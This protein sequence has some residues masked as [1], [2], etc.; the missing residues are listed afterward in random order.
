M[1]KIKFGSVL[2]LS[3]LTISSLVLI[4]IPKNIEVEVKAL[5]REVNLP[6]TI[7]LNNATDEEIREYYSPLLSLSDDELKGENLLKNLKPI[8]SNNFTY[9]SYDNVWKAYEITDRNWD[10]APAEDMISGT[11][12]ASDNTITGYK[13]DY[14][15]NSTVVESSDAILKILY[16]NDNDTATDLVVTD[17]GRGSVINREH[18]WPQSRGF[19]A[20]SG[21]EGP[22]GTDL[23]HLLPGDANVNQQGHNN[24]AYGYV[25]ESNWTPS[26]TN[27]SDNDRGTPMHESTLNQ[28]T[29][30]FEPQDIDK[31]DIARACFYMVAR[32][33]N[34]AGETGVISD[35]EP[36]LE[37]VDYVTPTSGE[38]TEY[39]SDTHAVGYGV[40]STLL[41][42]HKLDPVDEFEIHR[43]NLIYNNYQNN[44]NPFIDFPCWV[45][46]IW[47]DAGSADVSND[48]INSYPPE[49]TLTIEG[50]YESTI[51]FGS[52]FDTSNIDVFVTDLNGENIEEV[53][54]FASFSNVDTHKLGEQTVTVS[55]EGL[56]TSFVINVTNVGSSE[57]INNNEVAYL[58]DLI[59]ST[60][61]EGS[62]NNKAIEI[63]NGTGNDIDL[64]SYSLR[65]YFNGKVEPSSTFEL[66]GILPHNSTYSIAHS[67]S[68]DALKSLVDTTNNVVN[69][70]GNDTIMLYKGEEKIDQFGFDPTG[71]TPSDYTGIDA[72]GAQASAKDMTL[73][74]IK[75]L[76]V[77]GKSDTFTFT[78]WVSYP[79]DTFDVLDTYRVD[80]ILL[81][82]SDMQA[83]AYAS[84]FLTMTQENCNQLIIQDEDV[85]N[86]L[87]VE[88]EAM[89]E[90][91]K[92]LFLT[93][94]EPTIL[95]ARTRYTFIVNKYVTLEDFINI[96]QRPSNLFKFN[97]D[98]KLLIAVLSPIL[99]LFVGVSV[100][101]IYVKKEKHLDK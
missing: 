38:G 14:D 57:Y 48:P 40:L 68:G 5:G 7:D 49:K 18:I 61:I 86:K 74:R 80:S 43:N 58:D 10:R 44:R 9:I 19:K 11:Y 60:Y 93:S 77:K 4:S 91:S 42:W 92:Q 41:E 52:T 22:A 39:S 97:E 50:N 59:I 2:F 13:Y 73:A 32:Y 12:D 78:E 63:F 55:Y 66:E 20:D 96:G 15:R 23:H 76:N 75:D 84:Y 31:G 47:G 82:T 25:K 3:A 67:S 51:P 33:N 21:A 16:R 37:L 69:F 85:W 62:S 30:V 53:T 56:S 99:I 89:V 54:S 17:D 79:I 24:Y 6:A 26:R 101:A 100:I 71:E 34:L 65:S 98:S 45:D 35:F 46:V 95:D 94:D 29:I 83:K 8:L 90:D 70:N 27:I 28:D 87:K 81:T 88:Y 36:F 1:K 64:S 72:N